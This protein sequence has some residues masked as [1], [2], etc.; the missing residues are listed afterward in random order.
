MSAQE[1]LKD[2]DSEPVKYCPRCFSLKVRYEEAIGSDCCMDC[3]CS[4]IAE[5]SIEEWE[6]MYR[7]RYGAAYVTQ[8]KDIRDTPI[9][10]C[11][12]MELKT[13]VY[14][15]PKYRDIIHRM[16]PSFPGGLSRIDSV[17]LFFDKLSKDN[18]INEL[19]I[20]LLNL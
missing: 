20:I 6:R 2:Y 4:D 18:R 8:E 15:C 13:K 16:Y 7:N 17:L 11:T 14:N 12:I 5:A 1:K 9:F 3:G 10:K 19:R